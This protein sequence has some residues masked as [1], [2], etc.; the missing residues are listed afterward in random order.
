MH[1]DLKTILKHFVKTRIYQ[2]LIL[3]D[4]WDMVM[5]VSFNRSIII[6]FIKNKLNVGGVVYISYNSQNAW[7]NMIP[8][9]EIYMITTQKLWNRLD[10]EKLDGINGALKFIE[11]LEDKTQCIL[12]ANPILKQRIKKIQKQSREYL[13]HEYF[14]KDWEAVNFAN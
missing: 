13:A 9:K 12:R 8:V 10:Q 2:I 14:N 6:E 4:S 1:F 5:D 3:L 7:S 11:K